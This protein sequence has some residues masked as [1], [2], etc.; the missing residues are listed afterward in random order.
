[1]G[2]PEINQFL[3]HL[4]VKERVAASTQ[5]Q[6]LSAIL[7]LYREVLKKE[8]GSIGN[9]VWAKKPIRRPVVFTREE[10]KAVLRSLSGVHWLM[11]SLLY[12]CGLRLMECLQLR[13]KDIDFGYNQIVVMDGK[14]GKDRVTMLPAS[15]KESLQQHLQRVKKLHERDLKNLFLGNFVSPINQ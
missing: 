6:A 8:V 10:A 11:A 15:L 1:M 12:G 2:E 5:N 3:T 14:G 13:V 9:V 4:A 7:F